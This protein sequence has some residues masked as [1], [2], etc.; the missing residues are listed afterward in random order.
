MKSKQEE[1][2]EKEFIE[3][4]PIELERILNLYGMTRKYY[5]EL[6]NRSNSWWNKVFLKKRYLTYND[7]KVLTDAIGI[8]TFDILLLKVRSQNIKKEIKHE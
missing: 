6:N 3:V 8:D 5:C 1:V 4:K 7:I 2:I